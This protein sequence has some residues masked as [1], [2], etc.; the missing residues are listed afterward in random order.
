MVAE[1][2]MKKNVRYLHTKTLTCLLMVDQSST[3]M[4]TKTQAARYLYHCL[5]K[6]KFFFSFEARSYPEE[7]EFGHPGLYIFCPNSLF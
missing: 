6:N 5:V 1:Q 4:N 2:K 7:E 3:R